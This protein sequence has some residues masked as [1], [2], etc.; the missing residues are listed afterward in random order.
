MKKS[1]IIVLLA[2]SSTLCF[3]WD[4]NE[5]Q[6]YCE[7]EKESNA[8]YQ[9]NAYCNVYLAST[10]GALDNANVICIDG[11]KHRQVRNAVENYFRDNPEL[12]HQ[13]ADVLVRNALVKEFPCE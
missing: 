9:N 12:L 13:N 10:S 2:L 11:H 7:D 5:L 6:S 3:S 1:L 8:Y 4:G